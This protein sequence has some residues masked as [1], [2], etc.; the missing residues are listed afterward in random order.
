MTQDFSRVIHGNPNQLRAFIS[1]KLHTR[2]DG[3]FTPEQTE[4]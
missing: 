3:F 2:L 4:K 1:Q